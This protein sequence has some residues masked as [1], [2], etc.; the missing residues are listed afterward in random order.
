MAQALEKVA[1]TKEMIDRLAADVIRHRNK[2]AEQN[3]ELRLM[4]K[5]H[6]QV[7]K[8][9]ARI[10]KAIEMGVVTET[11]K[12]RLE[13]LEGRKRELNENIAIAKTNR[14]DAV[15]KEMITEYIRNAFRQPQQ[16]LFDLLIE[17]ITIFEDKIVLTLKTFGNVCPNGDR[18]KHIMKYSENPD[19]NDRGSFYMSIICREPF[20]HKYKPT[21]LAF[22]VDVFIMV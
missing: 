4:E 5:E 3:T 17:K 20:N 2:I 16:L 14:P 12:E 11:T 13:E 9:I 22:T 7:I 10:M 15:T 19:G 6:S 21:V 8:S 18:T 1:G